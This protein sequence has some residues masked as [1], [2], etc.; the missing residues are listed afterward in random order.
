[1]T[2]H[3]TGKVELWDLSSQFY[4]SEKDIGK[5]RALACVD[6]LKELNTAV[7]VDTCTG[8]I[9]EELLA[10]H[11]VNYLLYSFLWSAL[12]LSVVSNFCMCFAGTYHQN[13]ISCICTC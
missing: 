8:D 5:N 7:A 13:L 6:R 12:L 11:Q 10:N 2:L 9:T 1:M 4:F 3:D